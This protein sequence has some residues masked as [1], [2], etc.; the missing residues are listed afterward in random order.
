M[1]K[2]LQSSLPT[3]WIILSITLENML[4]LLGLL[5][6]I[7]S[8]RESLSQSCLVISQT[9]ALKLNNSKILLNMYNIY[10]K[11][12]HSLSVYV[13]VVFETLLCVLGRTSENGSVIS[14]R[15][16]EHIFRLETGKLAALELD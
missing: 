6:I 4:A 5:I 7:I 16:V 3:L 10:H 9:L 11:N 12:Y 1:I 2:L 8:F 14:I 13:F 15:S